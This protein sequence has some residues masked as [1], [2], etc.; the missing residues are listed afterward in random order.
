MTAINHPTVPGFRS[1]RFEL[2][3][4]TG[5]VESAF[6]GAQ[7]VYSYPRFSRWRATLELPKMTKARWAAWA[8]FFV[9][10]K[11]RN[12]TFLL[13][14]PNYGGIRGDATG[15]PLVDGAVSVGDTTMTIDGLVNTDGDTVFRAGD[16]ISVSNNLLMVTD[17]AT[18]TSGSVTVTFEPA[19]KI[20]VSDN[21]A[22]EITD[23]KGEFRLD[24]DVTGWDYDN[25]GHPSFTFSCSEAY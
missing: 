25:A 14:D 9:K 19:I 12:G 6:T 1:A 10:L 24:A 5:V 8:A 21:T 11:G 2:E 13:A 15:T 20:N 17:D 7:Q 4:K 3:R 22:V 23:P 18:V 16:Y